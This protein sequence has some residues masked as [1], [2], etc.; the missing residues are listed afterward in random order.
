M[1]VFDKKNL[2]DNGLV[3][4]A[5]HECT[6]CTVGTKTEGNSDLFHDRVCD[7]AFYAA[8][9]SRSHSLMRARLNGTICVECINCAGSTVA[10]LK[11]R[12]KG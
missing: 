5:I 2:K 8:G 7:S 10:A 9:F 11:S 4:A 1:P 6:M 3:R 12:C